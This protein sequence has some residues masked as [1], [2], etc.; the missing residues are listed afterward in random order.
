MLED[1]GGILGH[2]NQRTECDARG[3]FEFD[4]PDHR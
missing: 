2:G 3:R 1:S 4:N